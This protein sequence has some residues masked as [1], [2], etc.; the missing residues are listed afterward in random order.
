M[1]VPSDGGSGFNTAFG[2]SFNADQLECPNTI[3]RASIEVMASIVAVA[4]LALALL[5]SRKAERLEQGMSRLK[6]SSLPPPP[7]STME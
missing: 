4:G 3:I 7:L 6:D 5:L 2:P 1:P